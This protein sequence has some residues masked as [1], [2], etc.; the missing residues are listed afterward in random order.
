[1]KLL[2]D[3]KKYKDFILELLKIVPFNTFFAENVVKET[4][5]GKIFVDNLNAPQI[6]YILH[7]YGMSLLLGE[8]CNG[9]DQ[10][11]FKYISNSDGNRD[12]VE[13]MQAYPDSWHPILERMAYINKQTPLIEIDIRVNFNFNKAKYK[14]SKKSKTDDNIKILKTS[15][16]DFENMTGS[17]IPRYFWNNS[18]DF[19]NNG[20]GYSLYYQK[21]LASI[22][23]S[24]VVNQNYLEL[25]IETKKDFRGKNLA[26]KVCSA[27]IN[28][29]IK[30]NLEPIWACR[31][32]NVE[33]YNL[34]KKLG[35]DEF[36]TTP[37]YKLHLD[38]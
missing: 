26:Y 37:Y 23:F 12:K 31:K 35:F 15:A 17:V 18:N 29:C 24:S 7:P 20:V 30:K 2:N 25:G 16:D 6:F 33:S 10:K 36:L 21:T 4:V 1:M 3:I 8:N 32:A 28:H 34:A 19:I 14:D 13:W 9:F 11:L 22:A 27:L 5:N 38:K